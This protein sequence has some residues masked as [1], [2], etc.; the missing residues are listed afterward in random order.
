MWQSNWPLR[1]A[2][3]IILLSLL[4]LG[5]SSASAVYLYSQQASTAT[6]LVENQTS[7]QIAHD[8]K[9][10]LQILEEQLQVHSEQVDALLRR[11]KEQLG[12]AR[13]FA[14]KEREKELVGQLEEL[15]KQYSQD[16][17]NRHTPGDDSREDPVQAARE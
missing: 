4:L 8:L 3:P 5:L 14:D 15:F 1:V 17:K 6:G 2:G 9:N 13:E 11:I 12:Q 10:T 16:W 7:S